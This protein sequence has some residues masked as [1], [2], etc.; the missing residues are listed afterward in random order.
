MCL[1]AFKYSPQSTDKLILAANRDEFYKRPALPS[2]FWK[3]NPSIFAGIDLE[4]GGTWMGLNRSGRF[5][6]LTNYRDGR[7]K[8]Q[9]SSTRGDLVKRFLEGS[10][11]LSA[12]KEFLLSSSENYNGYNLIFME[13]N[14]LF[15]YSNI[16]RKVEKLN[17]GIYGLSNSTLNVR[18]QKVENAIIGMK[19]A[20]GGEFIDKELLFNTLFDETKA[21]DEMLPNTGIPRDWEQLLSSPFIRSTNYG[22]R[23]SSVV[24]FGKKTVTIEEQ[25][26]TPTEKELH[27][28]HNIELYR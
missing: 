24:I 28:I 21:R 19:K 10:D 14:V 2:H 15:Y 13:S 20:T 9:Y 6:A 11:T 12:Y 5:A 26:F 17:P 23:V 22:T 1:I 16:L 7:N 25:Y 8:K 3:E 18:W 4:G 27:K